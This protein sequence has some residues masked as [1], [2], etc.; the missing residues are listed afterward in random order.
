MSSKNDCTMI[1]KADFPAVKEVAVEIV[2][3]F[4]EFSGLNYVAFTVS[5]PGDDREYTLLIRPTNGRDPSD[6]VAIMKPA[7]EHIAEGVGN[8]AATARQ[9]LSECG[10]E[11][12]E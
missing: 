7:L 3:A 5:T 6:L 1:I 8:D 11:V 4:R 10:Y 2:R 9:A 12:K